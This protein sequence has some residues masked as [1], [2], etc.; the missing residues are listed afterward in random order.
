MA[1]GKEGKKKKHLHQIRTV[2]AHDGTH[3]HHH[4]YKADKEDPHTEPEREN[5]ATSS[6]AEEAGQHVAEQ[7]GMNEGGAPGGEDGQ[8][9]EGGADELEGG[10]G[11]EPAA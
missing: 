7:M 9:P 10:N 3:V 1:E 8:G 6:N 5:V 2:A 4:T 11:G